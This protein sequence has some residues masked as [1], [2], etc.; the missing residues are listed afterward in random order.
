MGQYT[1]SALDRLNSK[2]LFQTRM[3]KE[4]FLAEQQ[5]NRINATLY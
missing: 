3:K 1:V 5:L 4:N 2:N